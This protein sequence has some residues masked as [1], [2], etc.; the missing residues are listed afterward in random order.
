MFASAAAAGGGR[1]ARQRTRRAGV[2][3]GTRDEKTTPIPSKKPRAVVTAGPKS[4]VTLNI[5]VREQTESDFFLS[6]DRRVCVCVWRDSYASRLS[7]L[8]TSEFS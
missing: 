7:F 3:S 5:F 4:K 1:I 8:G 2:P 6:R